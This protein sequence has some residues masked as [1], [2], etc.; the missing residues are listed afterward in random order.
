DSSGVGVLDRAQVLFLPIYRIDPARRC[1]DAPGGN[2]YRHALACR[3]GLERDAAEPNPRTIRDPAEG[4]KKSLIPN[5]CGPAGSAAGA[6]SGAAA[7]ATGVAAEGAGNAG[8]KAEAQVATK[9]RITH[10]TISQ[11]ITQERACLTD[12][13]L[14]SCWR[15]WSCSAQRA[16]A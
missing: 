4:L 6:R 7:R 14:S 5:A 13:Q 15:A 1:C 8:G 11:S 2:V 10:P 3:G 12:L 9:R 16:S